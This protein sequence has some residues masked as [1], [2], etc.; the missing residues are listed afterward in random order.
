MSDSTNNNDQRRSRR[1]NTRSR[2]RLSSQVNL[3]INLAPDTLCAL[4]AAQHPPGDCPAAI[5]D[6]TPSPIRRVV[7]VQQQVEHAIQQELD[8][9]HVFNDAFHRLEQDSHGVQPN[10]V[11]AELQAVAL[12]HTSQQDRENAPT[13]PDVPVAQ[14][15]PQ[16]YGGMMLP[17][18]FLPSPNA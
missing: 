10:S 16:K 11:G 14:G 2:T 1:Y 8:T 13:L 15:L 9:L 4:C 12:A 18:L 17:L 3:H 5:E 7:Q 6:V